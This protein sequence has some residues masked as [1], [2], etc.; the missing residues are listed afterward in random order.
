MTDH[1][2]KEENEDILTVHPDDQAIEADLDA[3]Y[4]PL[5]S[6]SGVVVLEPTIIT[7]G[8]AK[9]AKEVRKMRQQSGE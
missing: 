1:L 3:Q 7:L 5:E 9:H 8:R 4:D 2:T 6:E